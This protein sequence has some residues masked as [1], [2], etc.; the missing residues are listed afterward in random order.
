M[1]RKLYLG[2]QYMKISWDNNFYGKLKTLV[3]TTYT[4]SCTVKANHF[5][6]SAHVKRLSSKK[7]NSLS[8]Q[9]QG[10]IQPPFKHERCVHDVMLNILNRQI[11]IRR[12]E[13][14]LDSK[15][16]T[17]CPN[18]SFFKITLLLPTLLSR[19]TFKNF[20][21]WMFLNRD[22]FLKLFLF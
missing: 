8:I 7:Q 12:D 16:K 10:W 4:Q 15:K 14:Q 13:E 20:V 1:G 22:C 19:M 3:S 21:E 18:K 6:Q 5:T 2:E 11:I 17:H 9:T